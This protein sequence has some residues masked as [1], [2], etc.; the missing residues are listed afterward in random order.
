MRGLVLWKAAMHETFEVRNEL[1]EQLQAAQDG[2]L[3]SE[4]FLHYLMETPGV[5][6]GE[7]F[8]RH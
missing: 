2:K 1:E 8:H 6:A 4:D 5:H 3:S 7:G